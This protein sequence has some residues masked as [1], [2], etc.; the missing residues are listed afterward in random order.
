MSSRQRIRT[1]RQSV[2]LPPHLAQRVRTLAKTKR[3]SASKVILDLIERGVAAQEEEKDR[4]FALTE[5]LVASKDA[6]EQRLLKAE[7]AELVFG[8]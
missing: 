6:A 7:L 3:T 2:S 5:R 4:F 8:T 1:H